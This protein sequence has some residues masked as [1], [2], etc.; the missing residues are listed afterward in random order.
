MITQCNSD[1]ILYL[2]LI[3]NT[4]EKETQLKL[5]IDLLK[6][7]IIELISKYSNFK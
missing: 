5:N 2:K 4:I 6:P 7:N 1:Q 3:N